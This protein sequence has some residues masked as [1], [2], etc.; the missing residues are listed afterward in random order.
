MIEFERQAMVGNEMRLYYNGVDADGETH[1]HR[2]LWN[3]SQASLEARYFSFTLFGQRYRS[4]THIAWLWAFPE[5]P[6][7]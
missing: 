1:L 6:Q 4:F 7:P 5:T 3:G 2:V